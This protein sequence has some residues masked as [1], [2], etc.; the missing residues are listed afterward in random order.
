MEYRLFKYFVVLAEELHFGRAA[1]RIGIAQPALSQQIKKMEDHL[2]VQLLMRNKKHV[3][4]TE[5]GTLFLKEAEK[6]LKQADFA[7]HTAMSAGRGERGAIHIGFTGVMLYNVLPSIVRTFAE[8]FPHIDIHLRNH[9][10]PELLE[11]L[12]ERH[13][14]A[15]FAPPPLASGDM[16]YRVVNREAMGI[17]VPED[18][19]LAAR[20]RLT[21]ADLAFEPLLLAPRR[22]SPALYD[23]FVAS[24]G[25]AGF[26]PRIV[27]DLSPH[28]TNIGLAAGGLGLAF[29]Y[30]S[31]QK[32]NRPG[33]V[34][35]PLVSPEF[36]VEHA[37][38]WR[39]GDVPPVLQRMLEVVDEIGLP[40][41]AA[42]R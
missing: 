2:G 1:E 41:A 5:A 42:V 34:Y 28:D 10:S 18:H 3:S 9:C 38:I 40:A 17:V 29:V 25:Q 13:I 7:V 21:I 4:L 37:I 26:T 15:A 11:A 16:D 31:Y 22:Y 6:A 19:R 27:H 32:L 36:M 23:R 12:R 30:G 20:E 8:R 33:V 24:C 14:Q 39:T 35:K